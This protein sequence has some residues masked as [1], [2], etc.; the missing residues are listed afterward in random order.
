MLVLGRGSGSGLFGWVGDGSVR[1]GIIWR[2]ALDHLSEG[3]LVWGKRFG[4]GR[5]LRG[6]AP[7][8][9]LG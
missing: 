4:G 6:M 5:R 1:H 9:E 3:R 8:V 2:S 7:V